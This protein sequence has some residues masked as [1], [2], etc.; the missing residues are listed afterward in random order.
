MNVVFVGAGAVAE[1]YASGLA[2]S[3]LDLTAMCDPNG[4][5]ADRLAAAHGAASYTDLDDLLASES[6][7]LVVNLTS[8]GAHATVTE[9]CLAA[10]RHVFSEKPLAL[11]ADVAT[12]LVST[13]EQ[14]G[15]ALGCAPINHRCDA[16]R[17][18]QSFLGDGRLGPVRLGYAH[19]HVGRVTEWHD[20]PD[21]FLA[22]GPL[23][24][25]AVYPLTVLVA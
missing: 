13:A 4:T 23:Y 12:A 18:V 14:R 3:E 25:G 6:A 11:D 10:D 7:P 1:K 17:H 20:S 19:A 22:V 2:E 15:L 8:H 24:D 9:R 21:S 16:Q 5:R